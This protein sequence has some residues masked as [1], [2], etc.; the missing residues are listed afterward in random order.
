[1]KHKLFLFV[2][3]L[4]AL[5]VING[6]ASERKKYNFNSEWKLQIGDFPKAKNAKFDDSQWKQVTL[7]HAFNEDEAFK[8]S[9]EDLTDT[10]SW[11]RKRFQL[12][13]LKSN[14]KVFIEFEGVRQGGDFYINGYHLGKHE[15]GV[16]AVGFDLTP[17]IKQ[18]E[19]LIAVRTD[20]SWTYREAA[21]KS[22]FQ[23]N[24]RNFNAN[25]GGI[26]KNVFLYVTDNVYQTLPLY[27]NLKTTGVYIYAKDIDIKR[28]KATIHAESE[29]RNDSQE[30]RQFSYQVTVLDADGRLIKSFQGDKITLKTGE[31]KIIKASTPIDNLHF[32]SWGYG[33]LYTVKTA[34]KDEN[35]QIF[36]EV[37]TRTGF[38][39][40][41]FAEGKIWLNDRIIQMKGYAQRT[42]NEWPAVGMSIPAWLSDYSNDLMVKS[43]GNLVRWM[44]ITPWKQ[45]VESCDRVGL[46]QA[47]PAG[48]S[49]KD[50][51]GRQW[52]QRVELM[53]DAIIYNR[54]NPS[55]LFYECGNESISR[56]HMIEMKAIRDKYDP[57]GGRAIGSREML[58]IREAE[59]GG[60]MLYINKSMHHPMWATEYCR[61][62]GLR[63]YW[64]EYSYPSH[65]EGDGPLHRNQPATSYNHNQDEFAVELVRRW[66]DYWRERPGTGTRVNSGGAKI[67]FSDSNTHHRGAE[68]YRRSGVT[69]PMRIEKDGF[70]AHQ[71]MWNGWVDT[72]KF[73][74]YI[75]GH[76][77][78]PKNTVK[79]IY[80]VSN[81]KNVELFLN[82]QSLGKGKREY[83][84][85][86][87]FDKVS[88]QPGKL[89]AV[90]YDKDGKEVSRYMISTVGE[91]AKLKLTT[92]QNP[93]GFHADGADMALIQ[94]EVVDN[95]GKRCPLDNRT[96]QFTLK[97]NA[98]WR[99]GIAQGKNNH[100]LD[101]NLPVECGINRALIRSTTTAGK[102]ILTAKA[103]GL[104]TETLTLETVPVKIN[105]GL[106]TYL[107]Q[108]TLKGKLD[109]G[110]TPSTP[111]Y[112]DTKK[113]IQILS[114]K[115]G[116]NH[117]E[118]ENSFDDNELSEWKNDGKLSTAWITYTLEREAEIDDVCLKLQ[119][120]RTR[121]Y[122]LEV[123]AGNKLIWS[124]NTDK[125]LGYV[126]LNIDNPVKAST[127]TIR[128]K[129]NTSDNDAFGEIT[130]VKAKVA[131]E[132]ELEKSK[133]KNTL[134][135]V[136]VEFLESIN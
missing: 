3:L 45:D 59:Y 35:N 60:E 41:R 79:P 123:F 64:D 131:N 76:W 29:V 26:P 33:Y 20:N 21:T 58:D 104:P 5:S 89:E 13:D 51:E 43:N 12:P 24:D 105:A 70:Y 16:M 4:T 93:E 82:G 72:D 42:S 55:I 56:E 103:E 129:G 106:S 49:E 54:N 114:A 39:K 124:G 6:Q 78:Y 2:F 83:N 102:I 50:R 69:D 38:R 136:E 7:P 25:Y 122:P 127:I 40:T 61:D 31:T 112:K 11:Y 23:W 66:Y 62:E 101:T 116:F 121:S 32:W 75:I 47:M 117:E 98:E 30:S 84:F 65:K 135:I 87:T 19:N 34:L 22:R 18:G 52:E 96:V 57:F 28:R 17:Y 125:S 15:N 110:A 73:Q 63:K 71:V 97:G 128:L 88:Y 46:I 44:H 90:S 86:F 133:S 95:N 36:D 108:A 100:I 27:S 119:G 99:G 53:R 1:M 120:W 74:T 92:I 109:K 118:A 77:N 8:V 91:P 130:E 80:V 115:A 134:R 68:N 14:Q 126:H 85:L 113:G 81:G 67:I 132:M 37:S 9:I 111:S 48:D 107:P 10:I 94:V